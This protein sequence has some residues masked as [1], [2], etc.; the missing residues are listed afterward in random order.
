MAQA[1]KD[2]N[3]DDVAEGKAAPAPKKGGM[4]KYILI[5]VGVLALIGVSVGVSVYMATSASGDKAAA[6]GKAAEKKVEPKI[7]KTPFYY[8]FDPPFVVNFNASSNYRFLQVQV[9]VLT[10]DQAVIP[11][12]EQ[13]LPVLQNNLIFL[14][15]NLTADQIMSNE[16]KAKIREDSLKVI[17]QVITDRT[18]KP[19]VEEVY[20]TSFVM[21]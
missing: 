13:N 3:Q 11:V 4:L 14:L 1:A 10:Y 19:G 18:G 15:S 8:K 6:D 12:I 7:T 17:Q 20:F 21:Q 9:E 5:A 16:G 2:L